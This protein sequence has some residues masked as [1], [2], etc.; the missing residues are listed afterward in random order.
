MTSPSETLDE[1]LQDTITQI[2]VEAALKNVRPHSISELQSTFAD[3]FPGLGSYKNVPASWVDPAKSTNRLNE[4]SRASSDF[5]DKVMA[6]K[7]SDAVCKQKRVFAVVGASH[8]VMQE[9]AIRALV[10]EKC[11]Q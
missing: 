11:S 1:Y 6:A 7:I 3:N 4:I 8:V 5:R 9:P 10:S 2:S